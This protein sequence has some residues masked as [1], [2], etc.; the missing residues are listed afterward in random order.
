M[1]I[2]DMAT[3]AGLQVLLDARIGNETYHSVSGSLASLQRFADAI[4]AATLA[5]MPRAPSR[6]T[7]VIPSKR[8]CA[9]ARRR[10]AHQRVLRCGRQSASPL[11][12]SVRSD[13]RAHLLPNRLVRK[14]SRIRQ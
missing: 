7:R 2:F 1:N 8:N 13:R 9:A 5:D 12:V 3:R 10:R 14:A 4:A 6:R 11:L